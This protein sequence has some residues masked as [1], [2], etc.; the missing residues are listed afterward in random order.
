M[1]IDDELLPSD[2]QL[3]LVRELSHRRVAARLLG[4]LLQ[5]LEASPTMASLQS[6][7]ASP[8]TTQ[9]QSLEASPTT[10]C[11][12]IS[13]VEEVLACHPRAVLKAPWSSS[14]RGLRFTGL[15]DGSGD[16]KS[17]LT[18]AL[19]GWLRGV[20]ARQGSVMVEPYYNK[21]K[22][23][24]MEFEALADGSIKYCGLSL[25]H[26]ANGA[27]TGNIVA[28]EQ[29]KR[30]MMGRYLSSAIIDEVKEHICHH[31]EDILQGRYQGPLGVDMMVIGADNGF[32][33]HPCV[34][35]NLRRTMGHAALTLSPN[36]DDLV[37]VMRIE[38]ANGCYRLNLEQS[39]PNRD[40]E[41]PKFRHI[42]VT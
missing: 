3:S 42:E 14:G 29:R 38:Y 21:V 2:E 27:Y 35:I 7:E 5:S 15:P 12:S 4:N 18:P 6:L 22:D 8:T 26:T 28:T 30:E 25:F 10:E 16:S 13:E 32:Q 11:Y 33:L 17:P 24:G 40:I 9:L 31:L 37:G 34:E 39:N 36:D 41:M 20:L 23:F 1:G 19:E